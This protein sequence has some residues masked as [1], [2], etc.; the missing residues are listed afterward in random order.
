MH[1]TMGERSDDVCALRVVRTS[2]GTCV[3]Y[4]RVPLKGPPP[5]GP[6]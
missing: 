4:Q 3:L 5:S 6:P 1:T 2:S